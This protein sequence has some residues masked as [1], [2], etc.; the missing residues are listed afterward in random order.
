MGYFEWCE[1]DKGEY[2]ECQGRYIKFN[3]T[4]DTQISMVRTTQSIPKN[5]FYFET[6]IINLGS[7]LIAI[8]LTTHIPKSKSIQRPGKIPNTI[9]LSIRKN[10]SNL[11]YDGKSYDYIDLKHGFGQISENGVV[12][13]RV[14]SFVDQNKL[15][16][17]CTFTINGKQVGSP[18]YLDDKKDLFPSITI[19][20][21]TEALLYTNF[22]QE[23]FIYDQPGK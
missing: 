20:S 1:F 7:N 2:I 11:F 9:G 18:H 15:Y 10:S 17:L 8:G 12:G 13:C 23:Q 21:Q 3:G 14:D 16:R 4:S 22:G 6:T 5:S 19:S